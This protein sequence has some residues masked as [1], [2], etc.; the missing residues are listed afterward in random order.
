MTGKTKGFAL[1]EVLIV[2]V[3]LCVL[4]AVIIPRVL[5]Q[6][7]KAKE[8][9]ALQNLGAIRKAE[10]DLHA[11]SGRFMAAVD[12]IA[13]QTVLGL[14]VESRFYRYR[15]IDAD[16]ENFLAIATP[17]DLLNNWLQEI[18]IDKDGFVGYVPFG[19]GTISRGSSGSGSS[20]GS[21]G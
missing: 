13:I 11:F 6:V 21:S 9:E 18:S 2:A 4:A 8:A 5:G 19:T 1:L 3:V 15:I 14:A 17:L 20:G 12:E 7:Q 16:Q 10:L